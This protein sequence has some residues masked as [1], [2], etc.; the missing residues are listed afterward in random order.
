MIVESDGMRFYNFSTYDAES[1]MPGGDYWKLLDANSLEL[2]ESGIYFFDFMRVW[3]GL[4]NEELKLKIKEKLMSLAKQKGIFFN[5]IENCLSIFNMDELMELLVNEFDNK[6]MLYLSTPENIRRYNGDI[7]Q[8]IY[9]LNKIEDKNFGVEL[10][11]KILESIKFNSDKTLLIEILEYEKRNN[12][13]LYNR[14]INDYYDYFPEEYREL[15][16]IRMDSNYCFNK[17]LEF[18]RRNIDIG[19]DPRISIAPEI[20]A[21]KRYPFDL[22]LYGQYDFENRFYVDSDATVPNGNEII[23]TRPF[24]NTPEDVAR[25]C[26]L[27]ET[28][29]AVGYYY[30]EEYYNAAG[31]INLGLDYLDTKEAILAFYEIYGNCEELLY[32]ISSEEG[33]IFRQN[34]YTSSRIKPLSEIIGKRV[35]EE[36]LS[37]EEVIRLFSN[38]SSRVS[39]INGLTYKKNS[40][41]LRGTNKYDYRFEFRIPNGGCNYETWIDN[42]RLYGKMMEKAKQIADLMKKDYLTAEEESLLRLKI[43]LQDRK[44]SLED[45]LEMLLDLLFEDENIKQIYRDRYLATV[46]KIY[47][48]RTDNYSARYSAYDPGFDEV[49]FIEHYQSRLDPDYE[50]YGVVSYDPETDEMKVGRRK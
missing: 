2:E 30:D 24:H 20:E 35:V 41:C 14:L 18:E 25:F 34:I 10:L 32:Y 29:R 50:G 3:N 45:K 38:D 44:L 5:G 21:N 40:V 37:R 26:A 6:I 46:R 16:R 39:G 7:F 12:I 11:A 19:I 49:E 22:D 4:K 13:T 15:L 31:Q 1:E 8:F 17:A 48:T 42:I 28:M 23:P 9:V 43:D 27:C 33:Q 47:E 36:D